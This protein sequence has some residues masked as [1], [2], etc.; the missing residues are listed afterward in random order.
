MLTYPRIDPVAFSVGPVDIY[1]YG[2]MYLLA[3][4]MAWAL[5][6]YRARQPNSGWTTEDVGD[7]IFYG[8]G[9]GML[10]RTPT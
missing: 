6:C 7:L 5:G 2:L 4:G 10:S 9:I 1:W 8:L 3:F